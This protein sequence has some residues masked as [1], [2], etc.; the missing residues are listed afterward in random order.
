MTVVFKDKVDM[1]LLVGIQVTYKSDDNVAQ[2]VFTNEQ[3]NTNR[4][5]GLTRFIYIQ[6]L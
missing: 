6:M 3:V 2:T 4:C 5:I 1:S